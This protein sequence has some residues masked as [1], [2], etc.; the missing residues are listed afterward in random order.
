[1]SMNRTITIEHS[2][3]TY[4]GQVARVEST[5]L[6]INDHGIVTAGLNVTGH[7]WG[8]S[9]GGGYCLD[10]PVE[11]DGKYSHR[12]GTGFGLDYVMT[13]I[14]TVGSDTWE[15]C[16]GKD[17]IVLYEREHPWGSIAAGIAHVSDED[18]VMVFAEHAEAWKASHPGELPE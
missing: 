2:G 5:A 14:K 1:M 16:K 6:G 11:V 12:E 4:Y 8:T 9:V 7:A 3:Q 18:K 13:V 10:T 15:G 17:V